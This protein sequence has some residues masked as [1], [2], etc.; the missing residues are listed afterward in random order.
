MYFSCRALAGKISE[1]EH[2][3]YLMELAHITDS[4]KK[5]Y[6]TKDITAN[7]ALLVDREADQVLDTLQ[8]LN[9]NDTAEV[10]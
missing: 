10:V 3:I 1:L 7:E 5:D 4:I 6:H 8:V 9:H 2:K